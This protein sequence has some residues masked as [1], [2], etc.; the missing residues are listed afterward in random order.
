[1][2]CSDTK[3]QCVGE[4]SAGACLVSAWKSFDILV[5]TVTNQ[6]DLDETRVY[7]STRVYI[8]FYLFWL[9]YLQ[10]K[11]FDKIPPWN[12][13]TVGFPLMH[14]QRMSGKQSENSS[15]PNAGT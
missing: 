5:Y 1:M 12:V 15:K 13:P 6:P 7:T 9:A 11:A 10:N 3:G 8:Y 14:D 4:L 2:T